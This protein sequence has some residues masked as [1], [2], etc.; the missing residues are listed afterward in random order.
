M[1]ATVPVSCFLF[2]LALAAGPARAQGAAEQIHVNLKTAAEPPGGNFQ[3]PFYVTTATGLKL[4]TITAEVSYPKGVIAFA[5]AEKGFLL[6]SGTFEV[7]TATAPN[8]KD[9]KLETL[10]VSVKADPDDAAAA[11]PRGLLLYLHFSISD[12]AEPGP[13]MLVPEVI[14]ADAVDTTQLS[15]ARW[16]AD[17]QVV[18]I[19]SPDMKATLACMFYMH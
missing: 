1:R 18:T 7:E 13:I 11:L 9:P 16:V 5:R 19:I 2:L 15:K 12:K 10:K 8:P 4:K 6:Q 14:A 3:T 17:K